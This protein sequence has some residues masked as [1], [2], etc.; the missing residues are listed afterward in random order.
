MRLRL[1]FTLWLAALGA[2]SAWGHDP[3]QHK[4]KPLEGQVMEAGEGQFVLK[5]S[6]GEKT[7][8]VSAETQYETSEGKASA[9]AVKKGAHVTVFGTILASGEMVAKEVIVGKPNEGSHS[10]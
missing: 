7:V 6:T 4:G 2:L 3:A 1:A 5:T 9:A 8:I 10:H